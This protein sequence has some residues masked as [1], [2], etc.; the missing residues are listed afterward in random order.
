MFCLFAAPKLTVGPVPLPACYLHDNDC[1]SVGCA[2][3]HWM[4]ALAQDCGSIVV[5]SFPDG[6]E[7]QSVGRSGAANEPS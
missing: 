7:M 2:A 3:I 4:L 6:K 1:A 5:P